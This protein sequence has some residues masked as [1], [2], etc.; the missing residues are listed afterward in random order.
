MKL[1]AYSQE[2]KQ[3]FLKKNLKKVYFNGS[4]H[5]QVC[6]IIRYSA[7]SII[8]LIIKTVLNKKEKCL[9]IFYPFFEENDH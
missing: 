9:H 8:L 1:L 2:V 4:K 6:H 5:D 7:V 3:E